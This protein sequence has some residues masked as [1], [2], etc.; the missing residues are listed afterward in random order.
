MEED[1]EGSVDTP[2]VTEDSVQEEQV[3][4]TDESSESSEETTT[5]GSEDEDLPEQYRGKSKQEIVRMH[6]EAEKLIGNRREVEEKARAYEQLTQARR[7]APL[8]MPDINQFT[9]QYG[10]LDSVAFSQAMGQYQASLIQT[11]QEVARRSAQEITDSERIE[12]D[13]PDLAN[14]RNASEA[15]VSLYESGRAKSLYDAARMQD[16]IRN[17]GK[18]S[19]VKEGAKKKEKEITGQMRSTTEKAGAKTGDNLSQDAYNSL[20]TEEK[21]VFLE[22]YFPQS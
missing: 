15:I 22:R 9:D 7:T 12:R 2:V 13:F 8:Q 16:K 6:Q 20:S 1:Q 4:D 21:K 3:D 5:E 17:S 14:D 11:S 10:N 18:E 19:G